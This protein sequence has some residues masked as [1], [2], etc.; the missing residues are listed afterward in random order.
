MPAINVNY[1]VP[2]PAPAPV[3]GPLWTQDGI[4]A[5]A[6]EIPQ[7]APG[8]YPDNNSLTNGYYCVTGDMYQNG[9]LRIYVPAGYTIEHFY[10]WGLG[11]WTDFTPTSNT[12]FETQNV[13][14]NDVDYVEY[15]Y[16]DIDG[17]GEPVFGIAAF[18][19]DVTQSN[20]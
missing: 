17:L 13:T 3:A 18:S 9:D 4:A 10:Q 15:K 7:S 20:S 19:F 11:E 14:I 5:H 16:S 2:V 12:L 1:H 8:N 6:V